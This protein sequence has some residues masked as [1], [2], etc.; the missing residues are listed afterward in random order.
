MNSVKYFSNVIQ[1][2]IGAQNPYK[3]TFLGKDMDKYIEKI[4]VVLNKGVVP[5]FGRFDPINTVFDEPD[6]SRFTFTVKPSDSSDTAK[7]AVF[8]FVN[9]DTGRMI[10]TSKNF[11]DKIALETYLKTLSDEDI[12][13]I[14]RE[15]RKKTE[16]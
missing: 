8:A 10:F 12:D 9:A 7:D 16:G 11:K 3:T 14:K 4:N 1:Y 6:D 5:E 13:H 2:P 15:L